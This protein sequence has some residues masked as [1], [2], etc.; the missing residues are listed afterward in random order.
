MKKKS[1]HE[2]ALEL[3]IKNMT[4]GC[5]CSGELCEKINS[6]DFLDCTEVIKAHFVKL[7]KEKRK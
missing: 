1:L 5:D 3:A 6:R 2:V 4:K 7:A